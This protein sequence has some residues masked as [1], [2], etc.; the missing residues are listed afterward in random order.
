MDLAA[1]QPSPADKQDPRFREDRRL[2]GRLLGA[3]IAE[4]AGPAVRETIESIRQTA[5]RF[6]RSEVDPSHAAG[7]R[8]LVMPL[9]MASVAAG[10]DGL[11]VETHPTP[12]H[13]L[14]D[15]AQQIPSAEF[16]AFVADIERL[17]VASGRTLSR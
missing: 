16:P 14:S 11:I 12:E 13:A 6:R 9:A 17:V 8:S 7:K 1:A 10:A 3:V 2:L 5:V 4:Q 15:A